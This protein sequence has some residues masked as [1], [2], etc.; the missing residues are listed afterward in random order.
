M[1]PYGNPTGEYFTPINSYQ[2]DGSTYFNPVAVARLGRHDVSDNS[3]ENTF[4]LNYK[5]YD[6]LQFRETVSYQYGGSKTSNF[7]PYNAIGADWLAWNVNNAEEANN[8]NSSI[9]TE[10]QLAFEIPF[11]NKDHYV[12]GTANWITSQSSYEWMNIQS[13]KTPSTD[14]QDPAIDAQ[15]N[16]MGNGSGESRSLGALINL[17]YKYKDRYI[18]NSNLRADAFSGF[19]SNNKWG[20]FKGLAA[21][22]RFSSEPFLSNIRL[23]RRE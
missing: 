4:R 1:M 8:L 18:I 14:I 13:N 6:W 11:K 12:S 16:W 3:L 5:F 23:A 10:S 7:L 9:R 21:A 2:G 19:G 15:I 20:L 22:W 17:N